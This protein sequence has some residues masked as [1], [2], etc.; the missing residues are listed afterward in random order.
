VRKESRA[1]RTTTSLEEAKGAAREAEIAR[2][3]GGGGGSAL[4]HARNLLSA[5]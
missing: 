1:N 5:K 2:M 4:E 3:L